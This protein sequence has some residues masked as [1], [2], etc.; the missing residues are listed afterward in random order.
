MYDRL[1]A[2]GIVRDTLAAIE[3]HDPATA[4]HARRVGLV[5]AALF[6]SPALV[7]AALLHDCGKL[8]V[9]VEVLRAPYDRPLTAEEWR[10]IQRHPSAGADELHGYVPPEVEMMIRYHHA[11]YPDRGSRVPPLTDVLTRLDSYDAARMRP[12]RTHYTNL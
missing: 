1:L 2:Q 7:M 12:R 6:S 9:P 5:A 10:E 4:A 3:A 8:Q 11:A